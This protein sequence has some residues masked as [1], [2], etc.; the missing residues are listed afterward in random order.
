MDPAH[1]RAEAVAIADGRILALGSGAGMA[2]LGGPRT[3]VID[4]GGATVLPGFVE[5]H[6]H[7]LPGGAELDHLNLLGVSGAQALGAALGAF[8][9]A[10]PDQPLI[11]AQ[12]ADYAIMGDRAATR[13][14]LDAILPDR[15]LLLVAADH[16]T[17]WANTAALRA[18]GILGGR[19]L[20]PGNDIV[21]APDGQAAGEL[22][23]F[24]AFGPVLALAGEERV[25]LGLVD[26]SEPDPAPGP[27][28]RAHDRRHLA[29]GLAHCARHGITSIVNMDGNRYQ[30]ELLAELRAEGALTARVRVPFHLR[31][32]RPLAVLEQASAM[33]RDFDDDWLASGFV[34]MFMDGVIDSGTAVRSDDYPDQP[35]WRGDALFSAE[36]FAA[37]CAEA[38][39]RGLQI[40]VHAIGCG[41]VARTLDG[42]AAARAA[43]GPRDAR[44][45]VEHIELMRRDDIARMVDLGVVASVQPCHV[46]GALDFPAFPTLD[47]LGRDRWRDGFL[48]GTLARAG[49]PVAFASDWPVADVCPLRCLKAALTRRPFA[50]DC[51]DERL[52]LMAALAAYT[53]GGA[54]AEH[55]EG[56]KGRLAPGFAADIVVLSRDIEATAPEAIDTLSVVRTIAGG[57][58]VWAG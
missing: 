45:R 20:D 46:P 17:A 26:G 48:T 7:L 41:A 1:P 27:S 4:A 22:R 24:Q 32:E 44:H 28:G 30:L 21:M 19:A 56:W 43:N 5:S 42:Y 37:A 11:C 49:V 57:R 8:A 54:Y 18:A 31:G 16:H 12:Q 50:K 15:P 25:H 35:G 13:G 2:A 14:D 52:D 55:T 58:T 29:R 53:T 10:R 51:A 6:M 34:K 39:R 23:E 36:Y 33:A 9:A 40:A 3:E 47:M 38:D